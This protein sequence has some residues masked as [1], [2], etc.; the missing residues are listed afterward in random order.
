M[1]FAAIRV[2]PAA[3]PLLTIVR[4]AERDPANYG[5]ALPQLAGRDLASR[6]LLAGEP[7]TRGNFLIGQAVNGP[8]GVMARLARQLEFVDDDNS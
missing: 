3:W 8:F 2:S 1:T 6:A 4:L 7:L 5:R